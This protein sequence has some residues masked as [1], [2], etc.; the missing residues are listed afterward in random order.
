MINLPPVAEVSSAELASALEAGDPLQLV[1]V[2]APAQVQAGHIDAGPD[3][4]FHNIVGSQLIKHTSI[5]RIGIY[6]EIPVAVI[7]GFGTGS[8]PNPSPV[9]A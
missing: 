3:A 9:L 2:R 5:N 7:C 1:D 6:P 4:M 8:F